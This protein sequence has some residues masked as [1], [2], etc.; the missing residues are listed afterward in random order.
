MCLYQ[1]DIDH[2]LKKVPKCNAMFFFPCYDSTFLKPLLSLVTVAHHNSNRHHM[3][4]LK[5]EDATFTL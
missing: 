1:R 5:S 4:H 3:P 2:S